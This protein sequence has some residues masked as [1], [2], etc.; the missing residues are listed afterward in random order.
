VT[1]EKLH[2]G[3]QVGLDRDHG[4]LPHSAAPELAR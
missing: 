4:V 2:L 1:P 3:P